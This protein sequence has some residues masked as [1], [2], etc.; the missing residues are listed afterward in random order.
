LAAPQYTGGAVLDD[1]DAF[2]SSSEEWNE[3]Y[4]LDAEELGGQEHIVPDSRKRSFDQF[5]AGQFLMTSEA[6]QSAWQQFLNC[7]GL[8]SSLDCDVPEL[9]EQLE[10]LEPNRKV[11]RLNNGPVL[12]DELSYLQQYLEYSS[13]SSSSSPTVLDSFLTNDGMGQN[14]SE[15]FQ[16][17]LAEYNDNNNNNDSINMNINANINNINNINNIDA[18]INNSNIHPDDFVGF[19]CAWEPQSPD[20]CQCCSPDGY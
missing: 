13:S 9:L 3:M 7:S 10:Q 16:E 14:D 18:N 6:E 1:V 11:R 12:E 2:S 5:S 17:L 8:S 20:F 19:I 4:E 15:E